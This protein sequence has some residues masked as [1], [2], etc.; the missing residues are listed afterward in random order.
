MEVASTDTS[1]RNAANLGMER[2]SV[3]MGASEI[4]GLQPKYLCHNLWQEGSELS[5]TT[6]EWS[7]QARPLPRP[8][9]SEVF[10]PVAAK[11][12]TDYPDLFQINTPIKVDV[13]KSFLEHH[14]NLSFVQSVC[15]GLQ[16]GF[17]PWA[18]TQKGVFP[19][20][21]DESHPAPTDKKQASFLRDQCLKER[22]KGHFS[23][24]FGL[25]LLPGMYSMPV[26]AVPKPS[27]VDLCLVMDHSTGPFSL[28]S[29]IEHSRVTGFPLD[30]LH[31]LGEILLDMRQTTGD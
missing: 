12:V 26:H 20:T 21:H 16:E 11:T 31:H 7:E 1:A 17:W 24:S 3:R 6:T 25:K 2:K 8:P 13:F 9:L 15:A 4:Y 18:D 29:M 27:S 5:P 14:P 23:D 10:N 19:A 30:N 22:Q 28:N